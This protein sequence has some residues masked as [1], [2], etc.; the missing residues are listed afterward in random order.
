MN[1]VEGQAHS[2]D[3]KPENTV[4]DPIP[5]SQLNI[6]DFKDQYL[7]AAQ[8]DVR[9]HNDK[10]KIK[11][12][13][14][15]LDNSIAKYKE[16]FEK[17]KFIYL[18]HETRHSFV[19]SIIKDPPSFVEPWETNDL[20]AR[21]KTSKAQL[22]ELKA[23]SNDMSRE[24]ET[25]ARD[26]V[27]S[28]EQ[29]LDEQEKARRL[30]AELQE[31]ED[32]L[33]DVNKE[34]ELAQIPV[35]DDPELNVPF[36]QLISLEIENQAIRAELDAAVAAVSHDIP[37]LTEKLDL[38]E[39][40][41]GELQQIADRLK[42][43]VEQVEQTREDQRTQEIRELET[44]TQ[45]FKDYTSIILALGQIDQFKVDPTSPSVEHISFIKSGRQ[46][47]LHVST[48]T[49]RLIDAKVEGVSPQTIESILHSLKA[50]KPDWNLVSFVM[51]VE[52]SINKDLKEVAEVQVHN[53]T[54]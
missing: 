16:L 8:A 26:V 22:K 33:N 23:K 14:L 19:E 46:Y 44:A 35:P 25:W 5:P 13:P 11:E 40:Q 43:Q 54:N 18:E 6:L 9:K 10:A 32:Q 41:V 34:L 20:I 2:R 39:L 53:M 7:K 29:V 27:S 51:E 49:Q 15:L 36:D 52:E 31:L 45:S 4:L 30:E 24:T 38:L 3:N 28:Y 1:A 47:A 21:N 37:S 48:V 50:V 17:R 12:N 42:L